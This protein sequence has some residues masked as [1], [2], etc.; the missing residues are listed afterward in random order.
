MTNKGWNKESER[1]K[2]AGMK[3]KTNDVF[4]VSKTNSHKNMLSSTSKKYG[5]DEIYIK[6]PLKGV[7]DMI[8]TDDNRKGWDFTNYLQDKYP[9]LEIAS[10]GYYDDPKNFYTL[11]VIGKPIEVKKFYMDW[12]QEPLPTQ[13]EIEALI[14]Q[15]EPHRRELSEHIK[16]YERTFKY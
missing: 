2:L 11:I 5:Y 3:I 16:K 8:Y 1:H 6:V 9:N 10:D 15:F 7:F 12:V 13:L 14:K 4:I